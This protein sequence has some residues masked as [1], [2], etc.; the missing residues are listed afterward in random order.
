MGGFIHSVQGEEAMTDTTPSPP[1]W[2][3]TLMDTD[4]GAVVSL[5]CTYANNR[6]SHVWLLHEFLEWKDWLN[7]HSDVMVR[8]LA[9][10]RKEDQVDLSI[11]E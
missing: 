10:K 9:K 1:K 8:E 2:D 7:D 3:V 4:L 5:D 6:Q 11:V